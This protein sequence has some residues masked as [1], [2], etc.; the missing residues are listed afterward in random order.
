VRNHGVLIVAVFLGVWGPRAGAQGA[1][2]ATPTASATPSATSTA[3]PTTT[4]TVTLPP[5][6]TI[7]TPTQTASPTPSS[8]ATASPTVTATATVTSTATATSTP[9]IASFGV[10]PA[11][12]PGPV[13]LSWVTTAEMTRLH[14]K[15]FTSSFRLLKRFPIRKEDSP[16]LFKA[17]AHQLV[18]DGLDDRGRALVAG[19]YYLFLSAEKGK[20]KFSAETQVEQP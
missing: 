14:A 10:S 2:T 8:T 9:G 6:G 13:T 12:L 5:T 1:P 17:G 7:D 19:R 3:S 20:L 18:W 15:V 4:W 11:S 16:D